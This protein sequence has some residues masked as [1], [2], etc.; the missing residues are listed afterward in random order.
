MTEIRYKILST[1]ELEIPTRVGFKLISGCS[2]RGIFEYNDR[3]AELQ[4]RLPE[5]APNQTV[6]DVYLADDR[7]RYLCD[8]VLTLNG[9]DPD[10]IRPRDLGWL[11]F[12]HRDAD[13]QP[14]QSPLA[15]INEPAKPRYPRKPKP[16][17]GPNDFIS[18]LAAIASHPDCSPEEALRLA[19]SAPARL[20]LGMLEER[21]WHSQTDEEK[22]ETKFKSWAEVQRQKMNAQVMPQGAWGKPQQRPTDLPKPKPAKK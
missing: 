2:C 16:D 12:G 3:M 7:F 18:M 21:A 20:M 14:Q 19:E 4:S 6:E 5:A 11:I 13:G 9:I 1:G 8:Q 10:W 17:E 22:D 15:V